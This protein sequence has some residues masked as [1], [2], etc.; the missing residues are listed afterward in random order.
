M[1][2][3]STNAGAALQ[4]GMQDQVVVR[5]GGEREGALPAAAE[6]ADEGQGDTARRGGSDA[7]SDL[8]AEGGDAADQSRAHAEHEH[9]Q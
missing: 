8:V 7:D 5:E 4:D 1:F 9:Q 3:E 2:G 6:D